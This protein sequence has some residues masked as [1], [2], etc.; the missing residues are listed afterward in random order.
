MREVDKNLR[1]G[2]MQTLEEHVDNTILRERLLALLA[3]FFGVLALIVSCLGIYGVTAF[4][5]TRRT[6]EIGIR[7]ALGARGSHVAWTVLREI[8]AL[9][10]LGIAI[11][12]P[13]ALLLTDL[14][15]DLLF[16]LKPADAATYVT[17]AVL[18]GAVALAAGAIPALHATR[19]D[20]MTALRYE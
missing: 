2:K 10:L 18:L 3:G 16:G 13:A 20:P 6:N 7:M 9:L 5:V 17:A 19:V 4:Q 14:A 12:I 15:E 11:G 1:V 8:V